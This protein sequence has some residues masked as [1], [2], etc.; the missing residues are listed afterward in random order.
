MKLEPQRIT[1]AT[2]KV[3]RLGYFILFSRI[4]RRK[5]LPRLS[6]QGHILHNE[7][8]NREL[9]EEACKALPVRRTKPEFVTGEICTED[10]F[11]RYL[12]TAIECGLVQ[13]LSGRLYDTKRGEILP[14]LGR[15]D[16]PF[17]LSLAQNYL[18][19]KIL[20]E[21]D[22]DYI[23][24]AISCA[25]ENGPNEYQKFF[26]MIIRIWR[27][28]LENVDFKNLRAYDALKKAIKTKW[29]SPKRYYRDNIKGPRLE[30]LLDL[31]AIE[32]WNIRKNRVVFRDNIE[33]F[34]RYSDKRFSHAFAAYMKPLLK[35]S[36]TFWREIP[37]SRRDKLVGR[38]LKKGFNLFKTSDALPKISSN[39]L[40]EYGLSIL[41]ESGIVCE[42]DELDNTLERFIQSKLNSYRYVKIMSDV[43]RGYISEL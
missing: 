22:Y 24:A 4:L 25:I 1:S 14:T 36:M 23:R 19:L 29:K 18:F 28:K 21:K 20:M 2:T 27:L 17:K 42:I 31:N 7:A 13:E 43:D 37:R 16:N 40:L 39:Q 38:I 12:G 41:A 9:L 32:F 3:R 33:T 10:A 15:S 35:G 11:E 30:W 34:L 8:R 5:P 6:L 26:D